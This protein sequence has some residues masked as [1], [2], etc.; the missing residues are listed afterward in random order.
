MKLIINNP[1]RIAGILANSSPKEVAQQKA[2]L[3]RYSS[4]GRQMNSAFDIPCLGKIDRSENSVKK[5]FSDIELNQDRVSKALFW[6]LKVNT[7][8]ETAINYLIEGELEK[9]IEIWEKVTNEKEVTSRNYSCFNNLGTL[10]LLGDTKKEIREGIEAKIKL[11]ESG[12]FAEFIHAVADQTY[13]IDGEKE[14]AK[15]VDDIL[16][17]FKGHYSTSETLHFFSN[18]NGTVKTYLSLKFTEEPLHNIETQ[19]ESTKARRKNNKLVAYE[20][21]LKLFQNCRGDL[22][23]LKSLLGLNDLKY[24]MIADNLAKEV[25]QCGID[26]F[27]EW[28]ERKDPSDDG[29]R[30][31]NYAKS[32]AVSSQTIERINSNIKGMEEFKD[33]EITQAIALLKSVKDAYTTNEAKI[34]TQVRIQEA[35]LKY[36]QLIDWGKVNEVIKNSID[37]DKVVELILSVIPRRNVEIIKKHQ[38]VSK[39]NEYK[40]LVDFIIDKPMSFS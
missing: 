37:W 12:S 40:T 30:L 3:I 2:R 20:L 13:T 21:G 33:K 39:Q 24:K 32:I 19:I 4:I 9:A 36:G 15:F 38:D 1:Y 6:L 25:M 26:Y 10:K 18:C 34:R 14:T 7:F 17:Q 23:K 28:E 31:L 27:K 22:A 29:L 35:S 8:D 16:T 5:A 11:I